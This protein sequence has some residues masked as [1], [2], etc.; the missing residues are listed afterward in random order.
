MAPID[1]MAIQQDI[2]PVVQVRT[3]V[4]TTGASG[5]TTSD[6]HWSIYLILANNTGSVRINMRAE[7]GNPTGLL[8]WTPHTYALTTSAIRHWDF[9]A[10]SGIQ[11]AHI[12]RLIYS[13]GRHKYE[14]GRT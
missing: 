10:A 3:V 11:V 6:N 12:S 1:P 5:P 8:E 2:R 13:L 14:M 9:P 4:H 7:Y